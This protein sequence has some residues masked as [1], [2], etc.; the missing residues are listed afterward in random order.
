MRNY[1]DYELGGILIND[2]Q[3]YTDFHNWEIVQ[4]ESSSLMWYNYNASNYQLEF[5]LLT[6][7]EIDT[8][9][10]IEGNIIK[11]DI[12]FDT[13][14]L[15]FPIEDGGGWDTGGDT[16]DIDYDSSIWNFDLDG[17]GDVEFL[18]WEIFKG[19]ANFFKY[20]FEKLIEFFTNIKLL[21]EKLGEAFTDEEKT[22]SF[23][24][25]PSANATEDISS[26]INNNVDEV[27]YKQTVLGKIDLFIKWF[28]AFFI[29]V[30]WLAFFIWINRNKNG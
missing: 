12:D 27:A 22:F 14:T 15:L 10:F 23:N 24:L 30:I 26:I 9:Y 7:A 16:G 6:I 28:I 29:L 19:I 25:I 1:Y 4:I 13:S 8:V 17:D 2:W 20:F 3:Y 18:N 11:K 21:I 5:F